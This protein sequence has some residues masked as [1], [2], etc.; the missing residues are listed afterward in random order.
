MIPGRGGIVLRKSPL[1]LP[2]SFVHLLLCFS[3]VEAFG[4]LHLIH[5]FV[6][7]LD[8]IW[9]IA[10]NIN[11]PLLNELRLPAAPFAL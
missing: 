2:F 4:L 7:P 1:F 3:G 5:M 8:Y 9:F 10:K 6:F 11:Y